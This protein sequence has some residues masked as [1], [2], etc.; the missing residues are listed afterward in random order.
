MKTNTVRNEPSRAYLYK[1]IVQ[2]KLY[3]DANFSAPIELREIAGAAC[4]S[5][6]HFIRL[7]RSLY[8]RTPHQYLVS[9]RLRAAAALLAG[10]HPVQEVCYAVGFESPT[11]FAALFRRYAG[12]TPSA[13]RDRARR[14]RL[15]M[16]RQ[17]LQFVPACFAAQNGW[18]RNF[19]EVAS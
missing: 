4:F 5:R 1:R 9:V 16:Q 2:A 15:L 6:F 14:R 13:Y 3:I 12:V 8:G 19:E 10:D 18:K 11:T 17:P 7:F